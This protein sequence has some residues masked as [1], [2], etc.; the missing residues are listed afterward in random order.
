MPHP[1]VVVFYRG[2]WCPYYNLALRTYQQELLPRRP[3]PVSK[4]ASFSPRLGGTRKPCAA[5][6]TAPSH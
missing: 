1:A 4:A 3:L 5:L 6:S 2:G